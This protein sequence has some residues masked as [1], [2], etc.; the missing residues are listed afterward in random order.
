MQL[1]NLRHEKFAQGLASGETQLQSYRDAG[2]SDP[3]RT[4]NPAKLARDQRVVARVAELRAQAAK[5]EAKAVEDAAKRLSLRKEKVLQELMN[6]GFSNIADVVDWMDGAILV[7]DSGRLPKNVQA[8]ISE[9]S[10]TA[11]GAVKV[12]MHSKIDALVRLGE[13]L[14]LFKE[15][16]TLSGNV[17][18]EVTDVSSA[19]AILLDKLAAIAVRLPVPPAQNENAPADGPAGA[20]SPLGERLALV[21]GRAMFP[22]KVLADDAI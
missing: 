17:E 2:F 13:H 19:R 12:K 20:T 1:A 16:V 18:V 8:A 22:A 3:T 7:R 14:G 4:G 15:H 11:N 5:V 6:I 10:I 21:A 9:V